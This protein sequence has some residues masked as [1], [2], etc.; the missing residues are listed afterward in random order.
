M[1]AEDRHAIDIVA[2]LAYGREATCGVK[3]N[4]GSEQSARRAEVALNA[5]DDRKHE[6]EAYP[7]VWCLGWHIGRRMG[8]KE[9]EL[10]LGYVNMIN[11]WREAERGVDPTVFK[12]GDEVW[13]TDS[14]N[15]TPHPAIVT[16][17]T[18]DHLYAESIRRIPG[19]SRVVSWTISTNSIVTTVSART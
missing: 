12:Q 14:Y 11:D 18:N 3:I 9:R 16:G 5:K 7:C 1:N 6:L 4:Y 15:D 2:G 8:K 17:V 10:W 13:I 19:D